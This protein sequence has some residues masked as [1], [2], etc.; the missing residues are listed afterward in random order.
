MRSVDVIVVG[1]GPAGSAA[2]QRLKAAGADVLVLDK[3]RFPRHKLCAGWITP[4]VVE[5]L[6]LAI[7]DYPHSF[8]SFRRLHWHWLGL[9]LPVPSVQHS[10]RRFEFDAWL[11]ERSGAEVV[12]HAVRAIRADGESYSIDGAFRCRYLIGAGGTACPVRRGLFGDTLPRTRALQTATLELEFPCEWRDPDCHLW[13][14]EHRLPGYSWYVPKA[15]GWLNIGIGG[16]AARLKQRGDNLWGHWRRFASRMERQ[17]GIRIPGDPTG[18]SYYVRGPLE[19]RSG[20]AFL[21]GDSA[22]LATRDLCEGIGPAI[23]SG[24]RAA[25]AIMSGTPYTLDDV[26]GASLGGGLISRSMDWAFT[27]G[28]DLETA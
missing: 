23:R 5:D 11:I 17:F 6:Q 24:H 4:Q 18:Y 8:L 10:I 15:C 12:Q 26:T 25:L 2:A 28:A 14:F 13:F 1:G 3:E 20:N 19:V 16:M 22:G 7:G 9:N 27:R 21:T